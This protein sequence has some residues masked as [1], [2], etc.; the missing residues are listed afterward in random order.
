MKRTWKGEVEYK[1]GQLE[2][3]LDELADIPERK[4]LDVQ[5]L[6]DVSITTESEAIDVKAYLKKTIF[7][8]VD[9]AETGTFTVQ[10]SPDGDTWWDYD[11]KEYSAE[12]T[13]DSW[14]ILT[15]VPYVRVVAT[16][17]GAGTVSMSAWI[18]ARGS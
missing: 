13:N 16:I 1:L 11:S 15:H 7:L 4:Y 12:T 9:A 5:L 2:T 18:A 10:I 17:A 8:A 6:D 14:E 3:K